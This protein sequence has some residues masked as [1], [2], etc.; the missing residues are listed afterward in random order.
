M[1]SI[2]T[3]TAGLGD[4]RYIL[5]LCGPHERV[6]RHEGRTLIAEVTIA[7]LLFALGVVSLG[8]WAAKKLDTLNR[9]TDTRKK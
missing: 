9:P 7:M 4:F 1:T 5:Q 8:I 6:G 2:S 3:R